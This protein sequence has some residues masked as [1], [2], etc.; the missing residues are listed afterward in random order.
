MRRTFLLL[1]LVVVAAVTAGAYT[2]RVTQ[3]R[4]T[5]LRTLAA[6]DV[7]RASGVD[8]GERILWIRLSAAAR[9]VESIP[10]VAT[11]T[12]SRTLPGTVVIHIT[13]RR[14]VA[15]LDGS[16]DLVTDRTGRI[17]GSARASRRLPVLTAWR[18]TRSNRDLDGASRAVVRA[19]EGFPPALRRATARI[20]VRPL[21]ELDLRSG[22]VV[23]FGRLDRLGAKAAA[24]LAVLRAEAGHEVGYIDVQVPTVPVVGP[25]PTP[26]PAAAAAPSRVPVSTTPPARTP[27]AAR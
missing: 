17:F 11:A 8:I 20:V 2:L 7:I 3:V 23:R 6:A 15:R 22:I 21:L 24:A 18:P 26:T 12:A 27:T 19:Y 10:A 5:G 13:E 1:I 14:A 25:P 16:A 4:V 9:R